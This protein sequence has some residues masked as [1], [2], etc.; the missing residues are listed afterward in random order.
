MD[1]QGSAHLKKAPKFGDSFVQAA[2]VKFI[3]TGGAIAVPVDVMNMS[4]DEIREF[5]GKCNGILFPGGGTVLQQRSG[6]PTEFTRR[7]GVAYDFA[8]EMNDNGY[9]FPIFGICLGFQIMHVLEAPYPGSLLCGFF[10]STNNPTTMTFKT[11]PKE[12]RLFAEMEESL[13]TQLEEKDLTFQNHHDGITP[14]IYE[15]YPCLG[16]AFTVIANSFD[17]SGV[18]YVTIVEHKKYPFYGLQQH[19][20]KST[21][22][23]VPGIQAPHCKE[24]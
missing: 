23:W 1:N 19:P 24:S 10:N 9:Y 14:E 8:K 13:I 16:D 2:Y 3:E 5:C 12:T 18:E 20:E 6:L 17:Q 21:A 22:I 11:T 7:C 15:K 4:D